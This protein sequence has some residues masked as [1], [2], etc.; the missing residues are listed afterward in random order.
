MDES[1][2]TLM[3]KE[4]DELNVYARSH[5]GLFIN[6]LSFWS[7]VNAVGMGWL[8]TRQVLN[9]SYVR[10]IT[11]FFQVTSAFAIV[12]CVVLVQH[13]K[14]LSRRESAIVAALNEVGTNATIPGRTYVAIVLLL[15][16]GCTAVFVT[17]VFF[18][19]YAPVR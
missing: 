8:A 11:V 3:R 6:W 7:A 16:C 17:W 9:Y 18:Y 2:R 19:L 14:Q 10:I 13:F 4:K 5:I 12:G 1:T 15:T